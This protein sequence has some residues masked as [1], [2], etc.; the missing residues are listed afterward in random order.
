M[1]DSVA[2]LAGVA[3]RHPQTAYVGLQKF[4]QQEWDFVQSVT[5]GIWMVFQAVEDKLWDTF[6]LALF[7]RGT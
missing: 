7:Q 1:E 3:R 6:L 2:T 4:L 5:P